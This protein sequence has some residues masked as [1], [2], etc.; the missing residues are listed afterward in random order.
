MGSSDRKPNKMLANPAVEWY[1]IQ[2]GWGG[3]E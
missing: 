1:H 3:G 2:L